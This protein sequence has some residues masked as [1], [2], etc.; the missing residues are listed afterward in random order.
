MIDAAVK[1]HEGS[2]QNLPHAGALVEVLEAMTSWSAMSAMLCNCMHATLPASK[3]KEML[4]VYNFGR[5]PVG[6]GLRF[7]ALFTVS[8]WM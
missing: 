7:E 6:L 4:Q 1:L 3:L 5:L 2:L 8:R